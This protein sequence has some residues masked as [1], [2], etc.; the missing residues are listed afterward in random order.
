MPGT[1]RRPMPRCG[2]GTRAA[3]RPPRSAWRRSEP[4]TRFAATDRM[5]DTDKARQLFFEA[6]GF[7]DSADYR[8]AE[9]RLRQALGYAPG[10]ASILTNLATATLRQDKLG[11][12][13]GFAEQALA[14]N[15]GNV[16][17]LM[18]LASCDGRE[19]KFAAALAACDRIIA[20]E[21]RI[22]EVHGNR[23]QALN[24]LGRFADALA[25]CDRAIA[26]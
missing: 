16:E 13:R 6:I 1:S 4:G 20:L 22:A 9:A 14:S 17:A 15:Q 23:A 26:L 11:E 21:P 19:E 8:S 18:V 12:A 10:N 7:F 3:S 25:S 2:A 5:N 24:G